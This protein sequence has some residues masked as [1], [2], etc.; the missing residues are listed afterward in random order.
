MHCTAVITKTV[1]YCHKSRYIDQWNRIES[2]EINTCLFGQLPY[3]KGGK[4]IQWVKDKQQQQ[5][6]K[7]TKKQKRQPTEWEKIF[8][9][10][11]SNKGLISKIYGE[12]TQFSIG[13]KS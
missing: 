6:T 4:N 1:W 12:F 11:I 13:E 3:D 7:Q 5:Q 9:N 2:P 8:S 10:D